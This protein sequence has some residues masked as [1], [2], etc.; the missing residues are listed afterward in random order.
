MRK[1]CLFFAVMF[2][3]AATTNAQNLK[4]KLNIELTDELDMPKKDSHMDIVE[5]D[6]GDF[7]VIEG[8]YKDLRKSI[9]IVRFD[10]NFKEIRRNELNM[11]FGDDKHS[12]S[13][14]LMAGGDIYIF[15]SFYDKKEK[16]SY[17][18]CQTLDPNTLDING[19]FRQL[20]QRNKD[21]SYDY[22]FSDDG[23][24]IIYLKRER[25]KKNEVE[26]FYI[27]VLDAKN[28][29]NQL[30]EKEF[31]SEQINQLEDVKNFEVNDDGVAYIQIVQY[32]DKRRAETKDGNPNY[33]VSLKEHSNNGKSVQSYDLS[34]GDSFISDMTF[35]INGNNDIVCTGFYSENSGS[36]IKGIFYMLLDTES[37]SIVKKSTKEFGLDFI[38]QNL[39]EKRTKKVQ[40]KAAKGKNIELPNYNLRGLVMED[41][42]SVIQVAERYYVVSHTA[43]DGNGNT[44]TYY[45]YHT[46]EI[47]VSRINEDGDI[48]W[49]RKIRKAQR[50]RSP[51]DVYAS[52]HFSLIGD[53]MYFIHNG[54]SENLTLGQKESV[55][56]W[57][58]GKKASVIITEIDLEG[59][60]N[61][62]KLMDYAG[63]RQ[64]P[65]VRIGRNLSN[66]DILFYANQKNKRQYIRVSIDQ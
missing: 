6:N 20:M 15:T 2:I 21:E 11:E 22:K 25:A 33:S 5:L 53:K 65:M 54:N 55:N 39:S 4:S 63:Y 9:Q 58:L 66:D 43:T 47:L 27:K 46:D 37:K 40:K 36:A 52:F 57:K 19:D 38:T 26:K 62:D 32:E 34:L 30:W 59:Y 42:G 24:K 14:L 31:R 49:I 28:N 10:K 35:G 13:N 7:V 12:F 56:G 61:Q 1:I 50:S 18:L 51:S 17:Q 48:D 44:Y 41:D 64:I 60:M 16:I 23:S 3:A 45:T 8:Q 29:F